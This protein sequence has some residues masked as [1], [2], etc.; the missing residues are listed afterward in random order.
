MKPI[1]VGMVNPHTMRPE[2]ALAPVKPG[3]AG[4]RLYLVMKERV[5]H[6]SRHDY[7]RRFERVNLCYGGW[8]DVKA[9]QAADLLKKKWSNRLVVLLGSPVREAF[10]LPFPR[11]VE[12][13]VVGTNTYFCLPHPSGRCRWYNDEVNRARAADLMTQL[14]REDRETYYDTDDR[15]TA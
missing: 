12:P 8:D 3:T 11:G 6:V 5:P 9:R 7:M 15:L 14:Y 1:L 10:G 13:I 4:M 2:M